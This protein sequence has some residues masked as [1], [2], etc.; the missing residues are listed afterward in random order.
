MR[1]I[2]GAQI[3]GLTFEGGVFRESTDG[4]SGA[5]IRRD[6]EGQVADP[7]EGEPLTIP[8]FEMTVEMGG[9]SGRMLF[10]YDRGRRN[11]IYSDDP[12]LVRELTSSAPD[13]LRLAMER[14]VQGH[15]RRRRIWFGVTAVLVGL[16]ALLALSLPSIMGWLARSAVAALP[17]SVD[18]TI[19]RHA[20]ASMDLG[21]SRVDD[22][23]IN[24]AMQKIL[25]RLGPVV[26][27]GDGVTFRLQVISSSKVN[28]FALPGGEM[29]VFTG[30]L[31]KA[32]SPG[33]VAG[34]LAHEMAH[35][36]RRHGLQRM[37]QSVGIIGVLQLLLGDA[38]GLIALGKE[39]LT[40]AAVNSYSQEQED[41][42]D[43]DAV[44]AL[45]RAGLDPRAMAG[46]F[47]LLKKEG[48]DIPDALSWLS[49]HPDN[50]ARIAAINRR[51]A[52]KGALTKRPLD[53]DWKAV[54]QSLARTRKLE[55]TAG[56]ADKGQDV[57]PHYPL[58]ETD[59]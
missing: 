59:K 6:R 56:T 14:L 58:K 26:P 40:L 2:P 19:G 57:H 41:E 49:T 29:V 5:T 11:T 22:P 21:G 10:C 20:V 25:S 9:A 53:V 32:D 23:V 54:K 17:R 15:R 51:A 28:A 18:Q 48:P 24:R 16:A 44:S 30:L 36:T 3:G 33:M 50:D 45:H 8:F 38:G 31:D 39:L 4:G 43:A 37:A 1:E 12:A 47:V 52:E 13:P 46:F 34:V 35:V 7:L 27:G 55:G 42:A